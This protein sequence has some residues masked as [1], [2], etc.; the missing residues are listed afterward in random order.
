MLPEDSM[1]NMYPSELETLIF[2]GIQEGRYFFVREHR[3]N[4]IIVGDY[5]NFSEWQLAKDERYMREM[6]N[7]SVRRS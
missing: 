1:Y 3:A 4:E 7:E 5:H 6:R 2:I